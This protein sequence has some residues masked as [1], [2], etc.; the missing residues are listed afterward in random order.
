MRRVA[1]LQP[2]KAEAIVLRPLLR[3]VE[4]LECLGRLFESGDRG[5]VARIAVGMI[6]QRQLAIGLG[7]LLLARGRSTPRTS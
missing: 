7:D 1:A 6:F 4:H 2:L 5:V 3:M